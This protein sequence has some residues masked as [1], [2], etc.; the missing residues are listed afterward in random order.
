MQNTKNRNRKKK[1]FRYK[2]TV[3]KFTAMLKIYFCSTLFFAFLSLAASTVNSKI[4]IHYTRI[5]YTKKSNIFP[6]LCSWFYLYN[7]ENCC[8]SGHKYIEHVEMSM[9]MASVSSLTASLKNGF[10]L[11]TD[12]TVSSLREILIQDQEDGNPPHGTMNWDW[13]DRKKIH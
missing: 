4:K 7:E 3:V 6:H 8:I 13:T 5:I 2:D 9:H 10:C 12:T 11:G 1:S